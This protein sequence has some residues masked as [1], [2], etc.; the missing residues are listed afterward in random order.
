M[1]R[2][3]VELADFPEHIRLLLICVNKILKSLGAFDAVRY[4]WKITPER[5]EKA[6]LVVAVSRSI[7]VG[8]FRAYEWLPATKANF[9]DI[10]DEHGNWMKQSGRF[11][12]HGSDAPSNIKAQYIGKRIPPKWDFKGNPIRY[13]NFV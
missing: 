12:F 5:A 8:V 11:G 13:V 6:E 4:S 10:Q 7:I 3:A 9:P 2:G 1:G